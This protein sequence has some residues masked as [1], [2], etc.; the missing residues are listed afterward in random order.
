VLLLAARQA[1][2][3]RTAAAA[4]GVIAI[5]RCCS[6]PD[7]HHPPLPFP[8]IMASLSRA[9]RPAMRALAA[10]PAAPRAFH[11]SATQCATLRELEGRVKS[12]KNIEKI[13]KV[14]SAGMRSWSEAGVQ[15]VPASAGG[16]LART[17]ERHARHALP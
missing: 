7:L 6:L 14:R 4:A 10:A 11:A 16:R 2:K 12:V 5:G 9:S 1:H 8:H 15:G 13:T 3:L 17:C